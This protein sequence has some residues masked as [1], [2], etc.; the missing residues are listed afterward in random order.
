LV[1]VCAL[2][3]AAL[4]GCAGA[5]RHEVVSYI[6]DDGGQ[7]RGQ[8]LS[9]R[10]EAGSWWV[11][12]GSTP[13]LGRQTPPVAIEFV[14]GQ[15]QSVRY[16]LDHLDPDTVYHWR[17]CADDQD[18]QQTAPGC[19]D[20]GSFTTLPTPSGRELP[21]DGGWQVVSNA[22]DRSLNGE[23]PLTFEGPAVLT[24]ID[25][26]CASDRYRVLD[27]GVRLG[28][29]SAVEERPGCAPYVLTLEESLADPVHYSRGSFALGPGPHSIR[30][31]AIFGEG[32]HNGNTGYIRADSLSP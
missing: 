30:L 31:R 23:G 17:L 5:T 24:V 29:T 16:N 32:N 20:V 21:V 13:Q 19:S 9:N 27:N 18:P 22:R 12:Y 15:A 6:D 1:A 25:S 4:T 11:E 2:A 26:Y 7:V 3:L 10:T 28:R 8:V 14:A